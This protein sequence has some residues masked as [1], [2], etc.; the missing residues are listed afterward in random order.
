VTNANASAAQIKRPKHEPPKRSSADDE[1]RG[2]KIRG[3]NPSPAVKNGGKEGALHKRS[4]GGKNT[5]LAAP[6]S[7]L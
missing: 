3:R 4:P 6:L 1:D 2:G 5:N 7:N